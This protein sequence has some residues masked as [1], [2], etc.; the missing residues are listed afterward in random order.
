[1]ASTVKNASEVCQN[2]SFAMLLCFQ[3]RCRPG[4]PKEP[5]SLS[6]HRVRQIQPDEM[7]SLGIKKKLR[8]GGNRTKFSKLMRLQKVCLCNAFNTVVMLTSHQRRNCA[9]PCP[10]IKH[11]MHVQIIDAT[12][13]S[14]SAVCA[15]ETWDAGKFFG[16]FPYPY[17]N[18][19]LHLGHAFSLSKVRNQKMHAVWNIVYIRLVLKHGKCCKH[20]L[21]VYI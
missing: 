20:A 17:M 1:M 9:C 11:N 3:V 19:M 16:N 21:Q 8:S 18:G 7:S 6:V 12:S 14:L 13:L 2:N 15:G 10:I 5:T 4:K